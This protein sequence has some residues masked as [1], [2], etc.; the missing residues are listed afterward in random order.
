MSLQFEID[1]NQ[2]KEEMHVKSQ[3]DILE[4]KEDLE[5][6]LGKLE[7]DFSKQKTLHQ[8]DFESLHSYLDGKI[9][10]KLA[11][12]VNKTYFEESMTNLKDTWQ[13]ELN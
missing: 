13:I 2:V 6:K 10:E 5:S 9:K 4:L 1:L 11:E 7:K 12:K 8:L 3:E